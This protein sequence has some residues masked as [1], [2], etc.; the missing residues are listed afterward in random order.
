MYA[1]Q[2]NNQGESFIAPTSDTHSLALVY[3]DMYILLDE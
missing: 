1:I 2:S 3:I